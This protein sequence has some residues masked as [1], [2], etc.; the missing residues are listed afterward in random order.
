MRQRAMPSRASHLSRCQIS[1]EN[2]FF[3]IFISTFARGI[4]T[5]TNID[6]KNILI[7]SA[8]HER[9]ESK[10]DEQRRTRRR[11]QNELQK[12]SFFFHFIARFTDIG[13]LR[14]IENIFN[15]LN[16]P[17]AIESG[18]TKSSLNKFRAEQRE[19]EMHWNASSA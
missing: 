13:A 10:R 18:I 5:A 14:L 7:I 16:F 9:H 2:F 15:K 6:N 4:H 1:N 11:K 3:S 19:R 17:I 8:R 12:L